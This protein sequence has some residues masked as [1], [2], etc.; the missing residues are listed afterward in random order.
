MK[1]RQ[2]DGFHSSYYSQ[3]SPVAN[4]YLRMLG[5]PHEDREQKLG[6]LVASLHNVKDGCS[7]AGGYRNPSEFFW[8]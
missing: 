3:Q 6:S 8:R 7:A 4:K 1:V 2:V 5:W